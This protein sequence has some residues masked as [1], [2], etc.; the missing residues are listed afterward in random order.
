MIQMKPVEG[1]SFIVAAGY[2][3]EN[4]TLTLQFKD[5]KSHTY[6]D[7]PPAKYQAFL[8]AKS[9]GRFMHQELK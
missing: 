4:R 6:N 3:A 8:A 2:D 7:V 1:S 5:G 9:K